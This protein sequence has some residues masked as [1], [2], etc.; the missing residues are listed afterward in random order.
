M[1][2]LFSLAAASLGGGSGRIQSQARCPNQQ[3]H[4]QALKRT[5]L[6][7]EPNNGLALDTDAA[8]PGKVHDTDPNSGVS[9]YNIAF[10]AGHFTCSK[11]DPGA[12]PSCNTMCDITSCMG[13]FYT[14]ECWCRKESQVKLKTPEWWFRQYDARFL[15]HE[16]VKRTFCDDDCTGGVCDIDRLQCKRREEAC[17]PWWWCNLDPPKEPVELDGWPTGF[18]YTESMTFLQTERK[19]SMSDLNKAL[20]EAKA[21]ATKKVEVEA[22]DINLFS[23]GTG[24]WECG[25]ASLPPKIQDGT[26]YAWVDRGYLVFD[27]KSCKGGAFN[28]KCYCWDEVRQLKGIDPKTSELMCD[29]GCELGNCAGNTCSSKPPPPPTQPPPPPPMDPVQVEA[30]RSSE[31]KKSQ[32]KMDPMVTF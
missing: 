14:Q 23:F 6:L 18:E 15:T 11:C 24:S 2:W 10:K 21:E 12:C 27:S 3:C 32:N 17:Q 5:A 16:T 31:L 26:S 7:Q 25:L 19:A 9:L 1:L 22:N 4:L 8:L 20:V 28:Q 13:E 29:S 30:L